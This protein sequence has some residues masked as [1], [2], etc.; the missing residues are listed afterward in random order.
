MKKTL[1]SGAN[2]GIGAIFSKELAR[3]GFKVTCVARSEEKLQ[4]ITKEIN[5]SHLYI[6]DV[7]DAICHE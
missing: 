1:I 2:S 6:S 4:A 3:Q 5:D 7:L